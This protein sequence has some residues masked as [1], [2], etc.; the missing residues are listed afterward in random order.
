MYDVWVTQD[1]SVQQRDC[2]LDLWFPNASLPAAE[3]WLWLSEPYLDRA[4]GRHSN[5]KQI[6]SVIQ[7]VAQRRTRLC[8]RPEN[9]VPLTLW[10][11]NAAAQGSLREFTDRRYEVCMPLVTGSS[12]VIKLITV[13]I[14]ETLL[15]LSA[16][17]TVTGLF[18][19]ANIFRRFGSQPHFSMYKIWFLTFQS[20]GRIKPPSV[21]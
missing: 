3:I 10:A 17:S 2:Y 4:A 21:P 1:I 5:M 14:S 16:G 6:I 13:K 18:L 12:G 19:T 7:W 20:V 11:A 9:R 15:Q 8:H